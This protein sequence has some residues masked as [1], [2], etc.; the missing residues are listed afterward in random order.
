MSVSS[1]WSRSHGPTSSIRACVRIPVQ[2]GLSPGNAKS[3]RRLTGAEL[4]L[5]PTPGAGPGARWRRRGLGWLRG[6]LPMPRAAVV[7]AA[8][9]SDP[10]V[11]RARVLPLKFNAHFKGGPRSGHRPFERLR[12]C[13]VV[14]RPPPRASHVGARHRDMC[15]LQ[16]RAFSLLDLDCSEPLAVHCL[17]CRLD[18]ERR[19]I[20]LVLR[21]LL[22]GELRTCQRQ[23]L[24]RSLVCRM[25]EVVSLASGLVRP[26]GGAT[27]RPGEGNR[28]EGGNCAGRCYPVRGVQGS[29]TPPCS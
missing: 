12:R 2:A 15:S 21:P 1:R 28:S 26:L 22:C 10:H 18:P 5:E 20:G 4:L 7:C 8:L 16:R 29:P 14:A 23:R 13:L 25:R 24:L 9:Q 11:R 19:T 17:L 6:E 3:P 27:L